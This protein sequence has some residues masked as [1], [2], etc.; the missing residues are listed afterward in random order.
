MFSIFGFVSHFRHCRWMWKID[1]KQW[2]ETVIDSLLQYCITMQDEKA[3]EEVCQELTWNRHYKL[4]N[5]STHLPGFPCPQNYQQLSHIPEMRFQQFHKKFNL[6]NHASMQISSLLDCKTG[7]DTAQ[8]LRTQTP[9][10]D[11]SE[12][13]P[14]EPTIMK[15]C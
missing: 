13:R 9:C 1:I 3:D 2:W 8:L 4:N 15:L 7:L 11:R 10:F 6:G 14:S 5:A 12:A